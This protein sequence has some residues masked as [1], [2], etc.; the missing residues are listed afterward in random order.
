MFCPLTRTGIFYL[1][2]YPSIISGWWLIFF[3]W[4]KRFTCL[5]WKLCFMKKLSRFVSIVREKPIFWGY[6]LRIRQPSLIKSLIRK[7]FLLIWENCMRWHF[8]NYALIFT[9]HYFIWYVYNF[10]HK[11]N[12]YQKWKKNNVSMRSKNKN[13]PYNFPH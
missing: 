8:V 13:C 6:A 4:W 10:E 2:W 12:K 7:S 5:S 9:L 3:I 1:L 11:L